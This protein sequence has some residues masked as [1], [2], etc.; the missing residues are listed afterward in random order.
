MYSGSSYHKILA[1]YTINIRYMRNI[2]DMTSHQG[3]PTLDFPIAGDSP[4]AA[5]ATSC[6]F[7]YFA[8]TF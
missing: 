7:F 4:A 5:A 8:A 3:Y 6:S 2:Y 1:I